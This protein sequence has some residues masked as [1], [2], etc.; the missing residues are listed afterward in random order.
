MKAKSVIDLLTQQNQELQGQL[1]NIL[2]DY[3]TLNQQFT[4]LGLKI[5]L[6][7]QAPP[8]PDVPAPKGEVTLVFTDVQGS[9]A[10]VEIK[11]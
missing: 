6:Y 9:T 10:Q 5:P 7:T 11:E 4:E 3:T 8:I 2:K 1:S